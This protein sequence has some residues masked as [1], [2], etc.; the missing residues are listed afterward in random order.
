[1]KANTSETK[2]NTSETKANDSETKANNSKRIQLFTRTS[3]YVLLSLESG[4]HLAHR[5][6]MSNDYGA[7]F[8]LLF[9][10]S[11]P[12]PVPR[13]DISVLDLVFSEQCVK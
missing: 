6:L 7:V 13:S 2:A 8:S 5:S 1:M 11:C 4:L 3:A 9:S 10:I 12:S